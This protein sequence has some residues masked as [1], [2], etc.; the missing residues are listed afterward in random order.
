MT[1]QTTSLTLRL[2]TEMSEALRTYAFVTGLSGNEIIKRAVTEYLQHHARTDM[3]RTAFEQTLS[4][5]QVA[6]DKLAHL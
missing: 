5:H 3:V 6:L 4:E 1:E 2:P